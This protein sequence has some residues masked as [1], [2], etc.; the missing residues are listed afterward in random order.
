MHDYTKLIQITYTYMNMYLS[1]SQSLS[2][3]LDF[4]FS[5]RRK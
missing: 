5:T 1:V 2:P 4:Q 3:T